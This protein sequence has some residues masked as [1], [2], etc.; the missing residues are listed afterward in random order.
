MLKIVEK[1]EGAL[2]TR[3]FK[4][5][6][7]YHSSFLNPV[8]DNLI[9]YV[10]T[11]NFRKPLYKIVS[12]VTQKIIQEQHE[13]FEFVVENVENRCNWHKTMQVLIGDNCDRFIECGPGDSLTKF[14]KFIDGKFKIFN[15][16][17]FRNLV[18]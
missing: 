10:N 14:A 8:L 9:D 16:G 18:K 17:K 12:T 4:V 15:I 13:I 5:H 3:Y 1:E 6:S 11:I 2:H 7:P